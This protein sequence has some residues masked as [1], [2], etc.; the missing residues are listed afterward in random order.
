[1]YAALP[2]A[3]AA[4]SLTVRKLI[5]RVEAGA[6]RVPSFQRPLRW[7]ADDVEKLFDSILR[8]YPIGSLLFWKK[9]L[10]HEK[11]SIGGAIID[12]PAAP[13]G[14]YIVDGQQRTTALAAS[15]LD[16]NQTDGRW[17]VR[18]DPRGRRFRIDPLAPADSRVH[19]PLSVLGDLRRLGRWFRDDSDLLPDEQ[20]HIEDVQQ[21]I[22]DYE[23]PCYVVEAD[24]VSALRG[25]FARL[26]STGVRMQAHEVFQALLGRDGAEPVNGTRS[27]DLAAL[28]AACDL[29]GFGQPS[30]GEVLKAVL[31]M[32]G[33]DPSKRLEDL[34]GEVPR[35]VDE[36]DAAEAL[37]RTVEFFQA[38]PNDEAPG[39]G[40]PAYAFVP[41][42][43]AFV[44]LARW[45]FLFPGSSAAA[46]RSLA[47]WL[48]RGV[49]TS[50]H[51]RAAVSAMRLQVRNI[52]PDD[53]LGS[54]ERLLESV[55][56]RTLGEWKL[57]PFH[58]THAASRVELLALLSLQP[59]D[60][61][62]PVSWRALL[63][64]GQRVAREVFRV[65]QFE[66]GPL[67]G[68]AR[69]V[70]NRV[71]LDARHTD[72]RAELRRWSFAKDRVALESH[73]IDESGLEEIVAGDA[74]PF[75]ERRASRIRTLVASFLTDRAALDAPLVLPRE[76][77]FEPV[78]P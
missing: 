3:P 66:R 44:I 53:E 48:W 33:L 22:L 15:L 26:N 73:L 5:Q 59:R 4:V 60:Q 56:E 11:I 39:P 43:V 1:M 27:L 16:L 61:H 52:K 67:R 23:L 51:Q 13:D 74:G 30:R 12:A 70:A 34:G 24:D 78:A 42:P 7:R 58:A 38:N 29:E 31:S 75:F 76:A 63:S 37:R 65:D 40:I 72:L 19:V 32:S 47:Q 17:S 64:D 35:L 71:L 68:L 49:A 21:R 8:G 2:K 57:D 18:Y 10:P 77:Y 46:R 14:W 6:I 55:P 20:K 62:G 9:A 54:L 36:G 25:V 28:Q 50:A 69:T 41:Y 45:F